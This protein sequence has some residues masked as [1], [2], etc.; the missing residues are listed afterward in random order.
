VTHINS[1]TTPLP[2]AECRVAAEDIFSAA[3]VVY[4]VVYFVAAA[5]N[6]RLEGALLYVV[7]ANVYFALYGEAAQYTA[8]VSN[9]P[10]VAESLGQG[11]W[12]AKTRRRPRKWP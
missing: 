1:S 12:L 3:L 10:P 7:P 11:Q 2:I 6:H 8:N 5:R 9:L 4:G